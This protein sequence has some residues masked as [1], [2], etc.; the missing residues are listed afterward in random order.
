[1]PRG[2]RK[3]DISSESL[4]F[5]KKINVMQAK[6]MILHKIKL[7]A[8]TSELNR[9][10]QLGKQYRKYPVAVGSAVNEFYPVFLPSRNYIQNALKA[11]TPPTFKFVPRGK[12][13]ELCPTIQ[14]CLQKGDIINFCPIISWNKFHTQFWWNL[15]ENT[16]GKCQL[17]TSMSWT[18]IHS[19]TSLFSHNSH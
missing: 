18:W 15:Q 8:V 10:L 7:R 11:V 3:W 17:T 2:K 14:N 1:M 6:W 5:L 16:R 12:N 9:I 4:L 13:H 19:N